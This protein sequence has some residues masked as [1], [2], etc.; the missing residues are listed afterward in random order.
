VITLAG[1]RGRVGDPC[2]GSRSC[3]SGL[4][5][6]DAVCVDPAVLDVE[7]HT[8]YIIEMAALVEEMKAAQARVDQQRQALSEGLDA[9]DVQAEEQ[10]LR[11]EQAVLDAMLTGE[12]AARAGSTRPPETPSMPSSTPLLEDL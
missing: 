1:C 7:R 4:Q 11:A 9:V 10:R 6:I 5:C 3:A 2:R 12:E 8:R